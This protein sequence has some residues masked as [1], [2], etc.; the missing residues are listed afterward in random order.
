MSKDTGISWTDNTF[1]PVWGC[2]AVSLGCD[3]CYAES[4][5]KRYGGD[6][7]G[8]GFPR[9]EFGDKHWNEPLK[10]EKDAARTGVKAKVFCASMADVMDDEWPEGTRERLWALIDSTPNLI[11]QLLTKRPSRYGRYLPA[12]FKHDNV[13]LGTSAETQE[14]Y[15]VRW[16]L[17][18]EAAN[19]MGM[20]TTFISYEPALGPLTIVKRSRGGFHSGYPDW[21]IAGGESGPKRRPM[22]PEWAENIKKECEERGV[23]FWMKQFSALT[24]EQGAALIPAELLVRQFPNEA[25]PNPQEKV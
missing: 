13:W 9:R 15:D 12:A 7:W 5:D 21:L 20:L 23:S 17:L 18:A 16:P 8:K 6:H 1:N 24:P 3:H 4:F 11:W 14:Y 19:A 2:T 25:I 22:N 10:W